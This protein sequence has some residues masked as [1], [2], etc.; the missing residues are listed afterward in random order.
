MATKRYIYRAYPTA[1]Q[2]QALS[3]LFGCCRVVA[4]DFLAERERLYRAGEH[5]RVSFDET[6]RLV[7]TIAKQTPERAFLAEVSAVPLQQAVRDMVRAYTNFFASLTVTKTRRKVGRPRFKKR[8]HR[9][10]ARFTRNAKFK[11]RTAEG[12]KWGWVRL[13]G[14][15]EVKLRS[16]RPLPSTPTSVTVIREPDGTDWVSFVVD[17]PTDVHTHE[18]QAARTAGLDA[19][20]GNDLLAI[21][22]SDGTREKVVNPRHLRARARKLKRLQRALSRKN[23]G[24][25]NQERQRMRVA[26]AHRNIRDARMDHHRKLAHRLVAANS[27]IAIET[28]SL[29]GL[30]RTRL[31]K[32]V[33]DA[34]IGLLY[35]LIAE[36]AETQGRTVLK[37]GRWEPTTQTCSVC[38]TLGGRKPLSVR[39][40][41]CQE[42][43]LRLDRDYNAAANVMVA[44]GLAE[45][46]N[47]CGPDIRR[48][49]ACA[50]G[51]EAGTRRTD[52]DRCP[53]RVGVSVNHD[54]EDVNSG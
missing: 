15:G 21:T 32:S 14:V 43:G 29:A 3:R 11:I 19:G 22:Y 46:L 35:R 31:A 10:T 41:T 40:W 28:L 36:M 33:H 18:P 37:A 1:G 7:T 45:T 39:E 34:G 47:A 16:T 27:I 13:P 25:A 54:G 50:D 44:A 12:C 2:H 23:T 5:K 30:G 8:T 17:A 42:C 48:M 24:S 51:D 20:V 4:N 6:A 53:G 49:L 26:R 52:P 38:G 9:Q